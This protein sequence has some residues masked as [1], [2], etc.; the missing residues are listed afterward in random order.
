MPWPI[1]LYQGLLAV[2]MSMP[3]CF[4]SAT[5]RELSARERSWLGLRAERRCK[6][7]AGPT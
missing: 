6:H 2:A 1:S 3:A 7:L 5:R 4:H